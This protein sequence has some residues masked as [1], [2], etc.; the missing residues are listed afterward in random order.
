MC[1]NYDISSL[2]IASLHGHN[3]RS[4]GFNTAESTIIA[5]KEKNL[6]G[7][8]ITNHGTCSGLIDHTF[9]CQEHEILPILGTELYVRPPTDLDVKSNNSGSGRYHMTVLSNGKSGYDR[10][11]HLNNAS[12]RNIEISRGTKYPISTFEMLEEYKHE[13]IIILTGCI[14]SMTFHDEIEIAREYINFLLKTF[15][16]NNVYAEIQRHEIIQRNTNNRINSYERPVQLAEEFGLKTVWTNDFHAARLDDLPLLEQY[17]LAM[18]GYSFTASHVQ[19]A[20]EMWDEAVSVIGEEQAWKAF[21]GIDEIV[22]RVK[23]NVPNFKRKF[24]LPSAENEIEEFKQYIATRL[25]QEIN[26]D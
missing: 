15:G 12:H 11:I 14:A 24:H 21:V 7:L 13:D 19:S 18:K 3:D 4:D 2:Q 6:V 1:N 26:N 17:T 25:E 22:E 10:L 23:N 20:Q 9:I 16:K 8:G 5:A